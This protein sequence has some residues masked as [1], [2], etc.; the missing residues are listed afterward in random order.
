MKAFSMKSGWAGVICA[1]IVGWGVAALAEEEP[2]P[3]AEPPAVEE[4]VVPPEEPAAVSTEATV[5]AEEDVPVEEDE[6][7]KPVKV[8]PVYRGSDMKE[9]FKS[10]GSSKFGVSGRVNKMPAKK[11]VKKEKGAWKRNLEAGMSTASGNRDILRYDGSVSAAKETEEN[12]FFLEA[13]GRYGES[14]NETDAASATGEAKVQHRLS[15]RTYAA[16]DGYARHDQLAD[17][18]YRVRGSLSLGRHFVWS[19]GFV[20]SA[21]LGP[22]YVTEK[23]GGE[24]EGFVAGRAAQYLEWLIAD[25]LQFWQSVEWV[26][27]LEDSAVYFV[28]AEIGLETVLVGNLNLR[29]TVENSYDSQP[30]EGKES[31]DLATKT[32]LVWKF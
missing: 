26:Q 20:L 21:E 25:N 23:K 13:G 18:S 7:E 16:L 3:A 27:N 1:G 17:L 22:G 6:P 19:D 15:E 31:N 5:P 9:A 2:V 4:T 10:A 28:N 32:A 8:K 11:S 24:K 30:A 29:F 14:D 12:Y